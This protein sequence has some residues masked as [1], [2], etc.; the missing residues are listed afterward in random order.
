MTH[1]GSN[2]MVEHNIRFVLSD[3]LHHIE[4]LSIDTF[5][6]QDTSDAFHHLLCSSDM[7]N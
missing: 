3:D 4:L 6:G 5:T 2:V 1:D 7:N